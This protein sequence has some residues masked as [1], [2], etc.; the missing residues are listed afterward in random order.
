L[1][2]AKILSHIR[3]IPGMSSIAEVTVSH[4]DDAREQSNWRVT[5]IDAGGIGT[6]KLNHLEREVEKKLRPLYA[7]STREQ[8]TRK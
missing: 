7:L 2:V 1:L 5:I 3:Q 4:I 8:D 6:E